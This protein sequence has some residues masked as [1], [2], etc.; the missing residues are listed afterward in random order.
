MATKNKKIE[1]RL[2]PDTYAALEELSEQYG[3]SIYNMVQICIELRLAG[4]KKSSKVTG[5]KYVSCAV[6]D[7]NF[8]K[9]TIAANEWNINIPSLVWSSILFTM[10]KNCPQINLD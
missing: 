4:M 8:E 5:Y 9:L 10:K 3:T 1:T 7:D 2:D 6:S